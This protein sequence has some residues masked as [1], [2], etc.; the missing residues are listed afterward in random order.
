MK[1]GI[2]TLP[3]SNN[4]GGILQAYALQTACERMGHNVE[5]VK[6]KS[7]E[8][9]GYPFYK[10]FFIY[11]KRLFLGRE[12]KV[13]KR[14]KEENRI[15]YQKIHDS[16]G[17]MI[18]YSKETISDRK[19]LIDY[20]DSS[21]FDVLVVGSDQVWRKTYGNDGSFFRTF[22]PTKPFPSTDTFF[23]D[24]L[25]ELSYKPKSIAYAASFG[26][27]YME[28][29]NKEIE[30]Y[31]KF[32]ESFQLVS[33]RE[34]HGIV[35][36][37][38]SYRWNCNPKWVLDPT[39]LLD[40][41]DYQSIMNCSK[42]TT[43]PYTLFYVLDETDEKTDFANRVSK[44]LSI[45]LKTISLNSHDRKKKGQA[46]PSVE[47]WLSLFLNAEYIVTDSYHGTVFA[48]IFKKPFYVIG[49]KKRGLARFHSLLSFFKLENRMV[50]ERGKLSN[51]NIDWNFVSLHIDNE[52]AKC[53][54]MLCSVIKQ[55]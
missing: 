7:Y 11:G 37:K 1:I 27:D 14:L 39:F 2:L 41:Q 23:L 26:V 49:N 21:K 6:W 20:I 13:E 17:R 29:N 31:G 9:N 5:V 53:I 8:F 25:S 51:I 38:D 18:H 12:I 42:Q 48:I 34:E 32:I 22:F 35:L 43:S 30:K 3:L 54:D 15:K 40:K 36:V 24:F 10:A 33:T 55:N 46:L 4:Y 45:P 52:K 44:E 16:I 19:Q 28:Y 50:D 47:E